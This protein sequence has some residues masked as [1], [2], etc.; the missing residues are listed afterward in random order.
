MPCMSSRAGWC[1]A[2]VF[3][4]SADTWG[5]EGAYVERCDDR[6]QG[7]MAKA[8]LCQAKYATAPSADGN[9]PL[10]RGATALQPVYQE[11]LADRVW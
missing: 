11:G 9:S 5:Y 4:F 3:G 10:L 8:R 2:I 7:V 6:V 1:P